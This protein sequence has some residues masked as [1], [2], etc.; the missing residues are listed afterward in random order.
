[1]A[2]AASEDG[3][4]AVSELRSR[5]RRHQ[6]DEQWEQAA[7]ALREAIEIAPSET[8]LYQELADVYRRSGEE[9]GES[10]PEPPDPVS[11]MEPGTASHEPSPSKLPVLDEP[12]KR[13]AIMGAGVLLALLVVAMALRALLRR[14]GDLSVEIDLPAGRSGNFTVRLLRARPA[15]ALRLPPDF[16][17]PDRAST[18]LEHNMVSRETLFRGLRARDWWVVLEGRLSDGEVVGREIEVTVRGKQQTRIAFDLAPD[19]CPVE[20]RLV[21]D[22][23]TITGKVALAGDPDS[24]RLAKR[25]RAKL[26]LPRGRH[27]ILAGGEGCGAE[28]S[29]EV[30]DF[31]PQ[32]LL[33]DLADASSQVFQGCEAAVEPFV[34]GDLSVA[35]TALEKAG[36]AEQ[37]ALLAARF[38]QELGSLERAASQFAEAGRHL[39]AAE[40]WAEHGRYEDAATHFERAG[41]LERAAEMYN[42]DGDLLRA[43]KA[44]MESGDYESAIIC[45]REAGEVPHLIDVLEKKGDFFEAGRLSMQR[46]DVERAVRNFQ[47][48]DSRHE[49]YFQTCR[50]LAEA[51]QKQGKDELAIQ[52]ADDAL[53]ARASEETSPRMHY[54]HADLLDRAGRPDRAVKILERLQKE[55]PG[56]LDNLNTR[57]ESM[58]RRAAELS[59]SSGSLSLRGKAFGEASRYELHDQIGSGGMGVVFRATDRRLSREVALK[60]LPENLKDHPRA[61]ELFLHEA[62]ASAGLNHPNIVTVHDVD[63]EGGIYF[64]TMELLRGANLQQLV[65][66]RGSL[67]WADA[68]RL[69]LQVCAGLAYAHERG[70]VHRDIKSA[71]LFFTDER[72]VKIMDFGLAKM[73]AEVRKATTVTG[74]TPYYM[75]PEQASGSE[76]VDPRADLYAFGVTLFELVTGKRPFEE[77]DIREHHRSTPAP[78]PRVHGVEVPEAFAEL[79][80][81]LMAKSPDDRPS[82][83]ESVS[84]RLRQLVDRRS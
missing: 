37:G 53:S 5:A 23:R 68:S 63:V 64:I 17:P 51:F 6:R 35:A 11:A 21:V 4:R 61:V 81:Q 46:H 52:K 76:Q 57:I 49:S 62:R 60:R 26:Q 25:G 1:R 14:S 83:A 18:E 28:T 48:V 69:G 43:G 9:P 22:G 44:Y 16:Q 73:M 47:R 3:A 31:A 58:R 24:V 55:S 32:T 27:Q 79:V 65:R 82:S 2:E 13:I 56:K 41:D 7:Q 39:E 78:D 8:Q 12:Q 67:S 29:L 84:T 40:L 77:G 30:E 54:W 10:L 75:A 19:A 15:K 70:L 38:H 42:A 66:A 71:N 34:R 20:L 72:I 45:Y 80:L 33:I 50:I 74:G 59:S 36:Q